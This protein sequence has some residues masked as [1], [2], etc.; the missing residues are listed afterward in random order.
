MV[1]S[2]QMVVSPPVAGSV[3]ILTTLYTLDGELICWVDLLMHQI[4]YPR[5]A[6]PASGFI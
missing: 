3:Q 2:S 1:V 5:F 6:Q 4:S